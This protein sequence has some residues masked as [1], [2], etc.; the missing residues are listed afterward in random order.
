MLLAQ[1]VPLS[2][3]ADAALRIGF[4]PFTAS[5]KVIV[6]HPVG[7][8]VDVCPLG[9]PVEP[10][11]AGTACLTD[12]GTGVRETLDRAGG[13]GALAIVLRGGGSATADVRLEFDERGR[14]VSVRIPLLAP[15]PGEAACKDNA[16]NP[17]FEIM[18]VRA[19]SF[20][21]RATWRGGPASLELLSGRVLARAF[22]ATGS[23]YRVPAE[24]LGS[25]P[26]EI[27]A[28]LSAP[29]EYALAFSSKDRTA[30][31]TDVLIDATWP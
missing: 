7:T 2:P 1:N 12:I 16:C 24:R 4:D 5:V 26:L 11:P 17:F 14:S 21:A 19:G 18:P 15:Y 6:N 9:T 29:A 13:L 3:G 30:E 28:S 22:T 27:R 25:S 23:P 10:V 31:L 20:R 8:R